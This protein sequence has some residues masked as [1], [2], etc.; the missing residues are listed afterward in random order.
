VHGGGSCQV[1]ITYDTEPGGGS[2]WK[3]IKSIEGGCPAPGQTGNMGDNADAEDPFE[4]NFTIP[5]DIPNGTATTAWTWFNKLG[6]REMY[7]NC[8]PVTLTGQG[9]NASNFDELPDIFLAH[10][11]NGCGIP[12]GYDITFPNPGKDVER[13]NGA[14]TSFIGPTGTCGPTAT[15]ATSSMSIPNH[16]SVKSSA[17]IGVTSS[18]SVTVPAPTVSMVSYLTKTSSSAEPLCTPEGDWKC[19]NGSSFQ[20]CAS[21]SWSKIQRLPVGVSCRPGKS[22]TLDTMPRT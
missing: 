8:G 14:T 12:E 3:V 19:V 20:R 10:I 2:V 21:G 5:T 1:S 11:S 17:T 6:N 15:P 13:L 16:V 4:Y 9:G 7:M 18:G 22:S